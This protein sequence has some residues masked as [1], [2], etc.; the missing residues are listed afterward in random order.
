MLKYTR[1]E[2]ELL[3]DMDMYNMVEQGIRGG[4]CQVSKKYVKANNKYL[5]SYDENKKLKYIMYLDA[6]NL[7]GL[8][9]SQ[10]LPY[11]HFEWITTITEKDIL[12]MMKIV[13][14]AIF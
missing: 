13:R 3:Y 6:N 2:L 8:S 12:I 14:L 5:K 9:M 7:Y 10:K 4:I 1:A 11:N